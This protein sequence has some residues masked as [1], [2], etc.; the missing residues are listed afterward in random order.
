M[1]GNILYTF[2]SNKYNIFCES[3]RSFHAD[4]TVVDRTTELS[5]RVEAIALR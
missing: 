3:A 2:P 4:C 1:K 5:P